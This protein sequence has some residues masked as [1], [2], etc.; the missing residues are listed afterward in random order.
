MKGG[1]AVIKE[2]T[3]FLRKCDLDCG[4]FCPGQ[5]S[6]QDGAL[7]AGLHGGTPVWRPWYLVPEIEHLIVIY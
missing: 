3:H 5:S 7:M 6:T 2:G 4:I 1:V